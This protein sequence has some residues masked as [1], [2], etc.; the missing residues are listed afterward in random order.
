MNE[1]MIALI[2][3]AILIIGMGLLGEYLSMDKTEQ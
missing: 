1:G 2:L 3:V